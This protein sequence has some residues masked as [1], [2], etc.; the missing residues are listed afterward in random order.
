MAKGK[1]ILDG[2]EYRPA[3]GG[4]VSKTTH[5]I[6]RGGQGGGPAFDFESE[7]AVHPTAKHA[8]GH[9]QAMFH[10][11]SGTD[12]GASYSEEDRG[13]PEVKGPKGDFED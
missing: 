5:K 11:E 8:A 12:K 9:L 10:S 13:G 7:D 6:A 1:R 3:K 4:I 2:V